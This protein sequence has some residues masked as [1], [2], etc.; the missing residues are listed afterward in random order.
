MKVEQIK[1]LQKLTK[2]KRFPLN[3][4]NTTEKERIIIT[5][6]MSENTE[7]EIK[8]IMFMEAI[9]QKKAKK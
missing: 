3:F 4:E 1:L 8:A 2:E 6:I 7:K 9:K 5:K